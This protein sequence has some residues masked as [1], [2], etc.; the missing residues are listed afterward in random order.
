M[1]Q[2]RSTPRRTPERRARRAALIGALTAIALVGGVIGWLAYERSEAEARLDT[3]A[4]RF[5]ALQSDARARAVDLPEG[6]GEPVAINLFPHAAALQGTIDALE[7][8]LDGLPNTL[9]LDLQLA[10]L[11]EGRR[12]RLLQ[13]VQRSLA[14]ER[15]WAT[16]QTALPDELAVTVRQWLAALVEEQPPTFE[17]CADHAVAALR[18]AYALDA[19]TEVMEAE[20][21][22]LDQLEPA[23]ARCAAGAP[24]E[25]RHR[26]ADALVRLA[27]ERVAPME[28]L[29]GIFDVARLM[30]E[31]AQRALQGPFSA[32]R[33][34]D[35]MDR[36]E[37]Q[38][39]N[40]ERLLAH[41]GALDSFDSGLG[42]DGRLLQTEQRVRLQL[43][44]SAAVLRAGAAPGDAA[45]VEGMSD[46]VAGPILV[47]DGAVRAPGAEAL[48]MP[49]TIP[50]ASGP[51]SGGTLV[52]E[53]PDQGA[54]AAPGV[55]RGSLDR[56]VIRQVIRQNMNA[57][58]LCYERALV[59]DP[60]LEGRVTVRFI[61]GTDG[62][63]DNA[64][65]QDSKL[66]APRVEACITTA[67]RQM[68]FPAPEG[69][70]IVIVA[71]PFMFTSEV[72][73]GD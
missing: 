66:E 40:A 48:V 7:E 69:G 65:V 59:D 51:N 5:E 32:G 38:I 41:R 61:I 22:T 67:V 15:A 19:V 12:G 60:T 16:E 42:V 63:V 58:R 21:I 11:D 37:E 73:A 33:A 72:P 14:A 35:L 49:S 13:I 20:A 3:L 50:L 28:A 26:A 25:A 52:I 71:Y 1:S 4:G 9:P 57:V 45:A 27:D 44:L 18:Y 17:S 30:L 31:G 24:R 68:R 6:L 46:P 2:S 56:E 62:G 64:L 55:N 54:G 43:R 70:G 29:M 34:E 39:E 8:P 36:A 23:I 10:G 47:E 53:S